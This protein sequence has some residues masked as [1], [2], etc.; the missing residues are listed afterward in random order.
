[1]RR[2]SCCLISRSFA[3]IRLLIVCRFGVDDSERDV[4]RVAEEIIS[5]FL[6]SP[7]RPVANGDDP[8]IGERSLLADLL[9]GP[10]PRRKASRG[11]TFGM[12]R[13]RSRWARAIGKTTGPRWSN[14]GNSPLRR[15]ESGMSEFALEISIIAKFSGM[16]ELVNGQLV[17]GHCGL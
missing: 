14:C 17:C 11:R 9:I 1:M 6:G 16:G 3:R 8:A 4:S 2:R 10:S 7:D 15:F 13:R 5:P 12:C